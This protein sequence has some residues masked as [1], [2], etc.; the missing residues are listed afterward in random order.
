MRP[1]RG[2]AAGCWLCI[3][4]ELWALGYSSFFN[5]FRYLNYGA[6]REGR[7]TAGT[8]RDHGPLAQAFGDLDAREVRKGGLYHRLPDFGAIHYIDI[9]LPV[10]F[11]DSFAR[12]SE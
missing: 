10:L 3:A 2:L 7:R 12:N 8:Q 4:C 1:A 11:K 9:R 6:V 5:L